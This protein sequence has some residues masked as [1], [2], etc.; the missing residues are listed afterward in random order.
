[1]MERWEMIYISIYMHIYV[2][3]YRAY[4]IAYET[5]KLGIDDMQEIGWEDEWKVHKSVRDMN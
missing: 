2:H 4:T 1:M 5:S 3:M